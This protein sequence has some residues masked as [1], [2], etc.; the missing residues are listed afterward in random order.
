MSQDV[1]P[2][3][4][5]GS[6]VVSRAKHHES[7]SE[8]EL[9]DKKQTHTGLIVLELLHELNALGTRLAGVEGRLLAYKHQL[10]DMDRWL[11]GEEPQPKRSGSRQDCNSA[12]ID[13]DELIDVLLAF[14][15]RLDP[16]LGP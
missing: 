11:R 8:V 12:Q 2:L 3:R 10:A 13:A 15:D 1:G 16:P 6:I 5:K 9:G 7:N 14:A 4:K